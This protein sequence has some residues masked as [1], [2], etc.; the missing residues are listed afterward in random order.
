MT[1]YLNQNFDGVALFS[2]GLDS[3]LA[4][5]LIQEQGLK[6]LGLHF[7]SPFFGHPERIAKW[8]K[9]YH[10]PVE[11]VD[12][13]K[14]F[15]SMVQS[16]P[17][18]GTGKILNPCVDCKIIMLKKARELMHRYQTKF[19]VSGEV[20][21]QRP[22]S[23]RRDALNIILRE[24][25]VKG[26]LVR[27]LSAHHLKPTTVEE[28][29]IVDRSKLE[30]ISGR[31]RKDQMRLV[32]KFNIHPVPTPAGGC[33]L[34]EKESSKR[35]LPLLQ[36]VSNL[37]PE[38]FMLANTGRQMWSSS[39]WLTIGRNKDDNAFLEELS[40]ENDYIIKLKMFPGPLGLGRILNNQP[41]P[42]QIV[43]SACEVLSRFSPKA[44]QS[45]RQVDV[46]VSHNGETR[47][48]LVWPGELE[49]TAQWSEPVWDRDLVHQ[50]YSEKHTERVN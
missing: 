16:G 49:H 14:E 29:G 40:T 33:L 12:I 5:H 21:G 18:Y 42:E 45:N 9:Q 28:A 47:E 3:I 4:I 23:Q 20:V 44:R 8:E 19:I 39:Y 37:K 41:W 48:L 32:K 50:I 27:P 1:K 6:V 38:D 7:C 2:G 25:D 10:I 30:S 34:T 13:S 43:A 24:A 35:Y 36:H 15:I 26:I 46:L 11:K 22:M 17:Q 31:G